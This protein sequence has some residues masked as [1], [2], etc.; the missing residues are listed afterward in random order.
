MGTLFYGIRQVCEKAGLKP[1]RLNYLEQQGYLPRPK[2]NFSGF[3]IY[4]ERDLENIMKI[5][6]ELRGENDLQRD[7]T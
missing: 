5:D 4:T 7:P 1:Y 3:R 2:K 6:R